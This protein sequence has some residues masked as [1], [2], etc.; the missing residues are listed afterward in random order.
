MASAPSRAAIHPIV[1]PLATDRERFE[2]RV[3]TIAC[4]AIAMLF[5]GNLGR[6]PIFSTGGRDVPILVNDLAVATV[7]GAGAIAMALHRSFVIDRACGFAL[8]F[9][10]LGALSAALAVPRFGLA[11]FDAFVSISYLV[12]WMFYFAVYVVVLNTIRSRDV[13]RVW[14]ALEATIL[15]FSV[16]G[17]FQS[18]FLPGFAQMVYP[19]SRPY[20]DWDIQGRRLVSTWL[21]PNYAGAFIAIGLVVSLSKLAAGERVAR[22]KLLVYGVA[23]IL[24]MSR[25]SMLAL[26]VSGCVLLTIT[27]L[28]KR[29]L[30]A[31]ALAAVLIAAALPKILQFAASFNK[32]SVDP[33]AMARLT[34]WLHGWIVLRDHWVIG[35]G[36]NT[37]GYVSE[38][39]GWIRS[40]SATYGIDGGLFFILVLTGVVGLAF[41]VGMLWSVFRTAL[42][43][44]RDR[45]RPASARGLALGAAVSIPFIVVHSLFSNSLLLPFL[46][47]PLWILWALP[48]V[49]MTDQ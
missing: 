23:L 45:Q 26:L 36:F 15:A 8:L 14:S 28:S 25:S 48:S 1:V 42:R 34:S 18:A 6:I 27:G 49:L 19:D 10:G 21:D 9:A 30:R 16:F 7:I 33:S 12:R 2:V 38:R 41:Y 20:L 39:Y 22:W 47:E 3:S 40:F 5:I 32:L 24:T 29:L 35:I 31:L 46:M 44:W 17:I 37:W 43:V 13:G 11:G 4:A